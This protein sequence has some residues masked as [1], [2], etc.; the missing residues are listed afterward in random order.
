MLGDDPTS[1]FRGGHHLSVDL[2]TRFCDDRVSGHE[3][4]LQDDRPTT[5]G[6]VRVDISVIVRTSSLVI[7]PNVSGRGL[8]DDDRQ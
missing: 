7:E 5:P 1:D 4:C 6:T 8:F 2:R 3:I